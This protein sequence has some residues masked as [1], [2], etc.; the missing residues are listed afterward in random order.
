MYF[1]SLCIVQNVLTGCAHSHMCENVKVCC[2]VLYRVGGTS[3]LWWL[4]I[5]HRLT[6]NQTV[7]LDLKEEETD[8]VTE[9]P[10]DHMQGL[11]VYATSATVFTVSRTH[12]KVALQ[13]SK[14]PD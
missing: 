3:V 8:G 2:F 9:I 7:A 12:R 6:M 14:Y 10:R 4:Y 11:L 13:S 5:D 1:C